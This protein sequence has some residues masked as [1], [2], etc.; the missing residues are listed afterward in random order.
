MKKVEAVINPD[1]AD[2][3][4]ELLERQ[5]ISNFSLCSIM[6]R[7]FRGSHIQTYRGHAYAVDLSPELKVEA[8]VED[9]QATATAY[10]I[11]DA[12][13]GPACNFKPRVIITPVTEVIL[14]LRERSVNHPKSGLQR[15]RQEARHDTPASAA[16]TAVAA[17]ASAWTALSHFAERIAAFLAS[18]VR[19]IRA[20]AS[21]LRTS[22]SSF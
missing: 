20:N 15:A 22:A 14:E 6:A 1:A 12:A 5:K 3:V 9:N 18:R 10:A 21:P 7:D 8:V 19:G 16:V 11:L 13:R 17:E 2:D 4:I